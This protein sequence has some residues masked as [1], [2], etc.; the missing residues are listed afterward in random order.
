MEDD[1]KKKTTAA[2][3]KIRVRDKKKTKPKSTNHKK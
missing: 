2:K 3:L 1:F